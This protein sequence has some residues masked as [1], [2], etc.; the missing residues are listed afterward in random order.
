MGIAV[1][2][3]H[4]ASRLEPAEGHLCARR[5]TP[6]SPAPAHGC[7]ASVTRVFILVVRFELPD[8]KAVQA[9]DGLTAEAV[10]LIRAH[11][12][13]TLVYDPHTV[14]GAPLSRVFYEVYRDR[15]AHA[16]HERQPHTQQFLTALRALV[17]ETRVEA[18]SPQLPSR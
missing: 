3:D 6:R 17:T 9:F 2:L 10:P 5:E 13:G 7:C 14:E 16:E 11:E 12:P 1:S 15:E 8:A 18:L 4:G